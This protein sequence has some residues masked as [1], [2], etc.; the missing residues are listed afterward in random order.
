MIFYVYMYIA[1]AFT[2]I[3]RFPDILFTNKI[4][5]FM[6]GIIVKISMLQFCLKLNITLTIKPLLCSLLF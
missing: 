3:K 2:H 4:V 5:K 1:Y 6:L